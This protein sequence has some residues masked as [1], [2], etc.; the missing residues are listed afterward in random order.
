[1]NEGYQNVTIRDPQGN[2]VLDTD[3]AGDFND[4][5]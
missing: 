1:M 4:R 3:E 2:D 5:N